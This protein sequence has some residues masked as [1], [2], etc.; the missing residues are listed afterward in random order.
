MWQPL[1]DV[2][3]K[4]LE[5]R[6]VEMNQSRLW[7]DFDVLCMPSRVEGMPMA[8]L[9]AA[10]RGKPILA[11]PVGELPNLLS[12]GCG[13]LMD[14]DDVASWR[15]VVQQLQSL[16]DA[17]FLSLARRGREA[18]SRHYSED[19]ALSVVLAQYK[20]AGHKRAA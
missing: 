12:N 3:L 19:A 9:E 16:D 7:R 11:T 4:N 1:K 10:A 18:I 5:L 15:N 2:P 14:G 13:F 17:T 20:K 8:A 6:G